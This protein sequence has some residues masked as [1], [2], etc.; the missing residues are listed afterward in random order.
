MAYDWSAAQSGW[1]TE[2]GPANS[3]YF[4]WDPGTP[5]SCPDPD[6]PNGSVTY[7]TNFRF[8]DLSGTV[9]PFAY[10]ANLSLQ[11]VNCYDINNNR[12]PNTGSPHSTSGGASD[13]SGYT[14]TASI[15]NNG[16]LTSQVLA[17][18]GS[19]VSLNSQGGM[20][21][22]DLNGNTGSQFTTMPIGYVGNSGAHYFYVLASDGSQQTYTTNYQTL[23]I[24]N[25]RTRPRRQAFLPA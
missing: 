6:W 17:A 15:N 19:S 14:F 2:I 7:W 21:Y 4:E 20:Y 5:G 18:D 23:S 10:F 9:H 16:F 13:G 11:L 22:G 8:V 12:D 1:N 25:P 3:G 24:S